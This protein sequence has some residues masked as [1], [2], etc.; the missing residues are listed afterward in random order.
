MLKIKA[1]LCFFII[2]ISFTVFS[3]EDNEQIKFRIGIEKNSSGTYTNIID[4]DNNIKMKST[5]SFRFF[6]DIKS[7][8]Y[9]YL[10]LIDSCSEI[11]LIFPD[12]FSV[13]SQKDYFYSKY[14]LPDE[15][16][17]FS[18]DDNDGVEE[19]ILLVSNERLTEL[20]KISKKYLQESS[21]DN[22]NTNKLNDYKIRVIEEIGIVKRDNSKFSV[23]AEKPVSTAG[24]TKGAI[25]FESYNLLEVTATNFYA[26]TIKIER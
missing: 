10:F 22:P 23:I 2:T 14:I 20:E 25:D 21:K 9:L 8:S 16:N 1:F 18:F 24:T 13:F 5:D 7:E 4:F 11:N 26:K 15:E 12:N 6:I 3:Q 19:F 17:W